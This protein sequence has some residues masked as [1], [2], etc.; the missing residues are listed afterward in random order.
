MVAT[1]RYRT[2]LDRARLPSEICGRG[3]RPSWCFQSN[4]NVAHKS[5]RI[6]EANN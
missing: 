6:D 5:T 4:L 2:R 1:L 3:T